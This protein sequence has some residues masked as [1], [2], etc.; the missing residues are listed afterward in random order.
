MREIP[1][2]EVVVVGSG[3]SGLGMAIKLKEAGIEDFTVLE[4]AEAIGGT[5]RANT[6]PGCACDVQSHLYS[7]SFAPN[8]DWTR[9]FAPQEEIR[10]YLERVAD[11]F[12]VRGT[13]RLNAAMTG[14]EWDEAA[15]VWRVEVNEVVAVVPCG[16]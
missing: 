1:D 14:A 2:L 7:F 9:M 13:I 15:A 6:Y 12:G 16:S 5:W 8:P 3:F 11:D 4:Q 10:A